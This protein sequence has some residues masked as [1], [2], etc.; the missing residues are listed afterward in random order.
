MLLGD[1]GN[2]QGINFIKLAME[3]P[4]AL[5]Y[6]AAISFHSWNG[7]TDELLLAWGDATKKL[8]FPLFIAEAGTDPQAYRDTVRLQSPEYSLD[9]INLYIRLSHYASQNRFCSGN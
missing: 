7:G 8:G 4:E 9:E 1:T 6:V 3:D 2:A 5:K